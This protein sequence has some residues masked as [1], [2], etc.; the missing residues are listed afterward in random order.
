MSDEDKSLAALP[1]TDEAGSKQKAEDR[2]ATSRSQ[3]D[4]KQSRFHRAATNLA[5]G[6]LAGMVLFA[7]LHAIFPQIG[8]HLPFHV[9]LLTGML[10]APGLAGDV[11]FQLSVAP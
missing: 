9:W 6:G 11:G 4:D 3:K 1:E 7:L 8:Q 10:A 5:M 2:Q